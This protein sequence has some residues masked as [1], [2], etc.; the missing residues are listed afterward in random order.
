MFKALSQQTQ[1][2]M[3]TTG[4]CRKLA[5]SFEQV[6]EEPHFEKSSFKVRRKIFATLDESNKRVVVKL[7]E[8]DQSVFCA[9]DPTIIYPVAGAWGRQG[10]TVIELTKVRRGMLEDA[11]RTA[12]GH[13]ATKKN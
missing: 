4:V 8:T 11:L 12:Y 1:K 10:W 2:A 7:S 13:V 9:F 3:V 5:T 6:T